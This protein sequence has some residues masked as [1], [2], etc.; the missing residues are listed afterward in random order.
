VVSKYFRS[1]KNT[2][3]QSLDEYDNDFDI[4][5]ILDP[6]KKKHKSKK[7]VDKL[8]TNVNPFETE[9]ANMKKKKTK[10]DLDQSDAYEKA[11]QM[12][13][14]KSQREMMKQKDYLEKLLGEELS[15][16]DFRQ[17]N[18]E[19]S[20][21][22]TEEE[23]QQNE[24]L[25]KENA[26]NIVTK[27]EGLNIQGDETKCHLCYN[28]LLKDSR[29]NLKK[30]ENPCLMDPNVIR[31]IFI[32]LEMLRFAVYIILQRDCRF[33]KMILGIINFILLAR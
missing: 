28:S 14:L 30:K 33:R 18:T 22:V 26:E 7:F 32:I 12:R 21:R 23:K 6:K 31:Y 9:K 3:E 16:E 25:E 13:G 2:P 24:K 27:T 5:C 29:P 20:Y 4:E 1:A 17:L 11:S 15:E 19:K 10:P 8:D